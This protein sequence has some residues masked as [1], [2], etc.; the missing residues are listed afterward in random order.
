MYIA[1][2]ILIPLTKRNFQQNYSLRR[3]RGGKRNREDGLELL[4]KAHGAA[5]NPALFAM[6]IPLPPN[7]FQLKLGWN[8]GGGRCIK[9]FLGSLTETALN[10]THTI[11]TIAPWKLFK[12]WIS[13]GGTKHFWRSITIGLQKAPLRDGGLGG[14]AQYWGKRGR[15]R[16]SKKGGRGGGGGEKKK[17]IHSKTIEK[18]I[19][20]R[21][22][23]PTGPQLQTREMKTF[24]LE[25]SDLLHQSNILILCDHK[26]SSHGLMCFP[27]FDFFLSSLQFLAPWAHVTLSI[28]C[29]LATNF[30][31]YP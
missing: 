2:L 1:D 20:L 22:C 19:N 5:V 3:A 24:P 27:S 12:L 29:F 23:C 26:F 15:G 7:N 17:E 6:C 9:V 11:Q 13:V 10:H 18:K 4:V 16:R 25:R 14:N 21:P 28:T 8:G 31:S 30:T